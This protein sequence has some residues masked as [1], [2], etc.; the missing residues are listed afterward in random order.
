MQREMPESLRYINPL[1]TI[2]TAR[3][4][5]VFASLMT[6]LILGTGAHA[7]EA[8]LP[9][10][11]W[12]AGPTATVPRGFIFQ[13]IDS[14]R[15][16]CT[17]YSDVSRVLSQWLPGDRE[18]APW[19]ENIPRVPI[20][21]GGHTGGVRNSLTHCRVRY[22]VQRRTRV[23]SVRGFGA[24]RPQFAGEKER[25]TA[26]KRVTSVQVFRVPVRA[27]VSAPNSHF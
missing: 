8:A 5:L 11:R 15:Y 13:S 10:G 4:V 16:A 6:L 17:N 3:P 24:G 22:K 1:H 18:S 23:W 19:T 2:F 27:F 9:A 14:P 21:V 25:A 12:R 26:G 7:K 20:A